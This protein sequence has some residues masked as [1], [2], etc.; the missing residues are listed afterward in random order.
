MD[1]DA[2]ALKTTKRMLAVC[3]ARA[4]SEER[5]E[6]IQESR[7]TKWS[8]D[9]TAVTEVM[10]SLGLPSWSTF[11]FALKIGHVEAGGK[12]EQIGRINIPSNRC[13]HNSEWQP[14]LRFG[15]WNHTSLTELVASSHI[16]FSRSDP[17]VG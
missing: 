12:S 3:R 15:K 11:M 2:I 13:L 6:S 5:M 10:S 14:L 17:S 7:I 8:R 4:T 1:K 16:T 9:D